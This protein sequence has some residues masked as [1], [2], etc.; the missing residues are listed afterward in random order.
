MSTSTP[1]RLFGRLPRFTRVQ[2]NVRFTP[3]SGH[4]NQSRNV[5]FVPKAD[6]RTATIEL[7]SITS[8]SSNC[9]AL[10]TSMPTAPL[11]RSKRK[12]I[13]AI[14][15]EQ[16]PVAGSNCGEHHQVALENL[17]DY[18]IAAAASCTA[19]PSATLGVFFGFTSILNFFGDLSPPCGVHGAKLRILS[20]RGSVGSAAHGSP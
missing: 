19:V 8:S 1:F 3:K 7:Y 13:D 9:I 17:T 2:T 5:R 18:S 20:G 15:I 12:L 14:A 4:R 11:Y 16:E 10:G 6:S